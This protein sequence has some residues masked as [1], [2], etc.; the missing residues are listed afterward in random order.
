VQKAYSITHNSTA[1]LKAGM[2]FTLAVGVENVVVEGKK[3]ARRAFFLL[4]HSTRE[5]QPSVPPSC[6]FSM[7]IAD[8][9]LVTD[10]APETLTEGAFRSFKKIGWQ[11]GDDEEEEAKV[12]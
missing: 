8:T 5:I 3:Y 4:M 11:L 12:R 6:S 9:I 1:E 10:G 2:V 7:Q